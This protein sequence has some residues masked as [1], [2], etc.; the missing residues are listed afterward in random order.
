M[1]TSECMN[2]ILKVTVEWYELITYTDV[3]DE[4]CLGNPLS[5]GIFL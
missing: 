3:K 4:A 2:G 5:I 1:S